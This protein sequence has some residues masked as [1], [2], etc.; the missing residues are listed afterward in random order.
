MAVDHDVLLVDTDALHAQR[1]ID[2]L[3]PK[4]LRATWVRTIAEALIQLREPNSFLQIII[5]NVSGPLEPSLKALDQ[6]KAACYRGNSKPLFL[7]ISKLRREPQFQ[8]A[9]ERRGARYV[10]EQ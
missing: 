7:C 10:H 2:R 4:N 8:L 5:L 1:L 6:L 9:V 3:R